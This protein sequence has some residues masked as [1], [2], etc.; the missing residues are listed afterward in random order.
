LIIIPLITYLGIN[1]ENECATAPENHVRVEG[2]IEK[3]DLSR[4][5][6]YLKLHKTGIINVV[7]DYFV[8]AFE[9]ERLVW[10]HF[11]KDDFLYRRLARSPQ[12]HE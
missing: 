9:E 11:V 10:R 4:E 7:F 6:P 12:S 2:R 3:I 1:D 5:I 8:C